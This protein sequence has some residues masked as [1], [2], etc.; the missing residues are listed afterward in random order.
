VANL[1]RDY[2][3]S[4]TGGGRGELRLDGSALALH[5]RQ[6]RD[7]LSRLALVWRAFP[8]LARRVMVVTFHT[9]G[10]IKVDHGPSST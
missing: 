10:T 2:G 7:A 1:D 6:L 3:V 8:P 9:D 4:L 5:A